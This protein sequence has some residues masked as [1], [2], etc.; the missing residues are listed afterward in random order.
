MPVT[1]LKDRLA[2]CFLAALADLNAFLEERGK[3]LEVVTS[4][5]VVEVTG[6][7]AWQT[8]QQRIISTVLADGVIAFESGLGRQRVLSEDIVNDINDTAALLVT[9]HPGSLPFFSGYH[10]SAGVLLGSLDDFLPEA[11]LPFGEAPV[12]WTMHHLISPPC[13]GTSNVLTCSRRMPKPPR[14]LLTQLFRL[15]RAGACCIT[16]RR[17]SQA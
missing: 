15:P 8:A 7:S 17:G 10:G 2:S 12:E 16:C 13:G 4:R 5:R 9:E 11:N 6:E 3:T 14:Y 1:T